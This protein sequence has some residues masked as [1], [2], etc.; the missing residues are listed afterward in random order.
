[1]QMFHR[2]QRNM[3]QTRKGG[4]MR[5]RDKQ[6]IFKRFMAG[7]S[8]FRIAHDPAILSDETTIESILREGLAGKLDGKAKA[9]GNGG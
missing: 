9:G 3:P 1:L 5:T 6:R 4:R 8:V 2:E 7:E